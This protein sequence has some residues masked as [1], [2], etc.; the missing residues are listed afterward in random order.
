VSSRSSRTPRPA[1]QAAGRYL[2][3]LLKHPGL[4]YRKLWVGKAGAVA[5]KDPSYFSQE[6]V[7]AI[8]AKFL[9]DRGELKP[10]EHAR[11]EQSERDKQGKRIK[12]QHISRA[13]QGNPLSK[14]TLEELIEAFEIKSDD[15]QYL[16]KIWHGET[17]A[18]VAEGTLTRPANWK[19]NEHESVLMHEEHHLGTDGLPAWHETR[20][21][22]RARVDDL[23]RFY[24][25]F[26]TNEVDVT[27]LW[28]GRQDPMIRY[29]E[30]YWEVPFV[31]PKPIKLGETHSFAYR[32][33]FHYAVP[34]LREYR[35]VFYEHLDGFDLHVFF[36]HESTPS[37]VWWTEWE[38]EVGGPIR[39]EELVTLDDDLAAHR[40]LVYVQRAAIGFRWEW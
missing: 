17:Y 33:D 3:W 30:N 35:R 1:E 23:E 26:D 13:L 24:Y 38:V 28:G 37:K 11:Y 29:N 6:A 4:S 8:Y 12:H 39:Y 19:P 15:A 9:Y 31:F 18:P 25:R 22:I 27:L 10:E 21:T 40:H 32:L 36:D 2:E 5:E 7:A 34:P 16:L 20:Q 14:K